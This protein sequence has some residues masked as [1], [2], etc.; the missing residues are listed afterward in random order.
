[1][2]SVSLGL[3]RLGELVEFSLGLLLL[4]AVALLDLAGELVAFAGDRREVVVGELAPLFLHLAGKLFPVALHLIPVPRAPRG[5]RIG[6][7][8]SS[9]TVQTECRRGGF[10]IGPSRC[11]A[12]C[13]GA[14]LSARRQTST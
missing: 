7:A 3:K 5:W 14:T 11:E 2:A 10:W 13:A 12:T 8:A 1:M 9:K 4:V 6:V